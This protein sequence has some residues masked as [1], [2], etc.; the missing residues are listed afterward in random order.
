LEQ[1]EDTFPIAC[2]AEKA[3]AI[4]SVSSQ[5]NTKELRVMALCQQSHDVPKH[6]ICRIHSR[7]QKIPTKK[8]TKIP[9]IRKL[10]K[11]MQQ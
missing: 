10:S 1:E 8:S 5:F 6:R 4:R 3:N 7:S 11:F 9:Q 2:L